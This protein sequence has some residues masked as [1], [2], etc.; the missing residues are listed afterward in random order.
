V[1]LL[2]PPLARRIDRLAGRAHRFHRWA[3]HPLCARYAA[4]VIPLGRRARLCRGCSLATAGALLGLAAGLAAPPAGGP[5]WLVAAAL[6][7]AL[8]PVSVPARPGAAGGRRPPKALTRL[9][10]TAV[11]AGALGQALAARTPAHLGAAALGAAAV[12]WAL[13]RYRR[14]GPDR[15]AC[16]ACPEGPPGPGCPGFAPVMKRERALSR[17]AGRW[18]ARALPAP[19]A[20]AV[21]PPARPAAA[22]AGPASSPPRA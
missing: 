11:A 18:I 17:L 8:V 10:P 1:S 6:L 13:L 19:P 15:A 16:A 5:P 3:H 12:A 22:A 7:L 9:A 20:G 14:R 4:E 21:T 2:A